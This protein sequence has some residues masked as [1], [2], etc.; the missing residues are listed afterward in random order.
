MDFVEIYL[1]ADDPVV[2]KTVAEISGALPTDSVLV[3]VARNN[4]VIV[5]HGDTVFEAGDQ[6]TAFTRHKEAKNLFSCLHG[7]TLG[8]EELF[9][10]DAK[11]GARES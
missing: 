10:Q 9:E 2:G 3:S 11:T 4:R 8:H 1:S 5:P 7:N 6:V